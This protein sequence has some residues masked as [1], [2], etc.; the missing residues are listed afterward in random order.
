MLLVCVSCGVPGDLIAHLLRSRGI[1]P[2]V[3]QHGRRLC[4]VYHRQPQIGSLPET[5]IMR[6]TPPPRCLPPYAHLPTE[7]THRV[8]LNL[9]P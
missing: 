1:H 9:E 8:A 6:E 5:I 4:R 3:L 2:G 7:V